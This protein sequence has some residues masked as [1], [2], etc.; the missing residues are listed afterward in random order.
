MFVLMSAVVNGFFY[1]SN[2]IKSDNIIFA[3]PERRAAKLPVCYFVH[4][5]KCMTAC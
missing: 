1:T 4:I 2:V 3:G 5:F